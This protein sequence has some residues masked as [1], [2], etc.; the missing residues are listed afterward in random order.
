MTWSAANPAPDQARVLS[1]ARRL[2]ALRSCSLPTLNPSGLWRLFQPRSGVEI[3]GHSPFRSHCPQ[4]R[5]GLTAA[6]HT[7]RTSVIKPTP[8]RHVDGVGE[9]PGKQ[10]LGVIKHGDTAVANPGNGRQERLRV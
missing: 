3:T 4:R 5:C 6:V 1:A 7:V 8:R 9:F 2:M 10:A